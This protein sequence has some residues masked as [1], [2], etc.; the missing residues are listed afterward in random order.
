[1]AIGGEGGRMFEVSMMSFLVCN[2]AGVRG[3]MVS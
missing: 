1:M 2:G 3:D